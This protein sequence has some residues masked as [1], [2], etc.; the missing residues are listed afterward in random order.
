ML[1]RSLPLFF[2]ALLIFLISGCS[3]LPLSVGER[4]ERV[5]GLRPEKV[6]PEE[7]LFRAKWTKNH[8][9]VYRSG[10]LPI[11]LAAPMIHQGVVYIGRDQAGMSAYALESGRPIWQADEVMN[12][13]SAPTP[14]QDQVIYGTVEGRVISRHALTGELNYEIDLGASVESKPVLADGRLLVHLRNHQLF[15]LDASTGKILWAYRR[16][17]P[18]LTTLQ[19]VSAPLVH[20]GKVFIGFAD[21]FAAAFS[22]EDGLLLWERRLSTG[23]KFVD[24]DT[25]PLLFENQLYMGSYSGNYSI[26][27]PQ[28]GELIHQIPHTV[29]QAA[30]VLGDRLVVGTVDGKVIILNRQLRELQSLEVKGSVT[31]LNL[32]RGHLIVATTRGQLHAIDLKDF[33]LKESFHFGHSHSA[34]FGEVQVQG[35]RLVVLSSRNRL[36]T[37]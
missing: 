31:S 19:R 14:F 5:T 16:A 9:P 11:G 22:L 1:T 23:A 6:R 13:H 35:E 8:D 36:Y 27:G 10:N 30:M 15:C 32:W 29:S 26:L 2:A 24:V 21:G 20:E 37:F 12:F 4:I 34:V 3:R 28:T 33:T 17:V 18:F 7:K 25:D